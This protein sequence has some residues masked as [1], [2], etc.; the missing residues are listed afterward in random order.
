MSMCHLY[1]FS[2]HHWAVH[3]RSKYFH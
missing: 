1:I 3:D 2:F